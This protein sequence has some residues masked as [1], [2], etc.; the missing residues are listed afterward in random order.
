M[1]LFRLELSSS[2]HI[3]ASRERV[4]QVF[5]DIR[6]WTEWCGVCL[7]A[8]VDESFGWRVGERIRLRLRM[9]R[10]GVPFDVRITEAE[11]GN[12]VAWA[13]TKLTVTAVRTFMIDETGDGTLVTDH[14]LF[15]SPALPIW[16]FYP[17]PIIRRMT[18]S[19]L[20][21]LKRE[22]ERSG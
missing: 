19:W 15:T 10:V 9:A 14:K 11:P 20:T 13:S 22:C 12:R 5:A 21:D 2:T 1:S 3:A 16:T 4:W 8:D 18:E 17:R 7:R 6:R